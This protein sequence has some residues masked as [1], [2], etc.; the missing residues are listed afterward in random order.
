MAFLAIRRRQI[1]QHQDWMIRSYV[2]TFAFVF[3]RMIAGGM[4]AA[5]IGTQQDQLTTAA[6]LLVAPTGHR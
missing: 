3:F 1:T 5:G 2:V 6:A 4:Q